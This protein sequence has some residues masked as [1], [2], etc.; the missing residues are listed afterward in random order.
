MI[1]P[2]SRQ[3]SLKEI[4][5]A[6]PMEGKPHATNVRSPRLP[7][8]NRGEERRH[9]ARL[10]RQTPKTR[11]TKRRHRARLHHQTPRK[12]STTLPYCLDT[13]IQALERSSCTPAKPCH[14]IYVAPMLTSTWKRH[15]PVDYLPNS[16]GHV[17]SNETLLVEI[18][19]V[20]M[21]GARGSLSQVGFLEE[22][23][24]SHGTTIKVHPPPPLWREHSWTTYIPLYTIMIYHYEAIFGPCIITFYR[25]LWDHY[26]TTHGPVITL[27]KPLWDQLC[28]IYGPSINHDVTILRPFM[29]HW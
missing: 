21:L 25:P 16:S 22:P 10:H 29:G 6:K 5:G 18:H 9:R 27:H 17:G 20:R 13:V 12:R 28:T 8:G 23:L 26:E 19:D 3:P 1:F 14:C 24:P 2:Y 4:R 11:S 15:H 7:E